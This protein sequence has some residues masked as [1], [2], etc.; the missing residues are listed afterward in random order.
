MLIHD[1]HGRQ[2]LEVIPLD[3]GELLQ[4]EPLTHA[5]VVA[6]RGGKIVLVFNRFKAHWEL[7]GGTI[8]SGETPRN[9]AVRELREES[10]L[11]CEAGALRFAGAIKMLLRPGRSH[12]DIRVE[13]GGLFVVEIERIDPFEANEEISAIQWWDGTEV[14]D[15]LSAIDKALAQAV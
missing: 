4:L 12:A 9:C 3:E 14:L 8:D 15:N 7:P 1:A 2:L 6:R 13:Y 5:V 11:R 10:G